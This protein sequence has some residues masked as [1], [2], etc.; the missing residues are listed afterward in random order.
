MKGRIL[1]GK[2]LVK[3]NENVTKSGLFLPETSKEGVNIGKVILL[4]SIP[5]KMN[6]DIQEGDEIMFAK[7]ASSDVNKVMIEDEEY[8]LMNLMDIQYIF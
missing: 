1:P 2:V 8:L 4:G 5:E 3:K 6:I 7:H